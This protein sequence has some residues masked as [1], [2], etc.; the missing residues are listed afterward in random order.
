M[1]QLG[2]ET[3]L[4]YPEGKSFQLKCNKNI[5]LLHKNN[6]QVKFNLITMIIEINNRDYHKT[7]TA[8]NKTEFITLK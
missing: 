8:K 2:I 3:A 4:N 1:N 6:Y 7:L 5:C